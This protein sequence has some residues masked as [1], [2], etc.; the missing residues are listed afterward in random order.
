M[1]IARTSKL[2]PPN[3]TF[4][5]PRRSLMLPVKGHMAAVSLCQRSGLN[6]TSRQSVTQ[7]KEVGEHHPD[8]SVQA[9]NVTVDVWRYLWDISAPDLERRGR[10]RYSH[11][12]RGRLGSENQSTLQDVSCVGLLTHQITC[13][14]PW[15]SSSSFDE[16]TSAGCG[17]LRCEHCPTRRHPS[18]R[19]CFRCE[20]DSPSQQSYCARSYLVLLADSVKA[21]SNT[22]NHTLELTLSGIIGAAILGR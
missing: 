5:R 4:R 12:R 20:F 19:E 14:S 21:A 17:E 8:P 13:R 11:R 1:I 15:Q 16:K 2:A 22:S 18:R 9:T 10:N 3:A 6:F 7:G